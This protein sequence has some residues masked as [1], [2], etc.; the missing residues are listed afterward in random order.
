MSKL[1]KLNYEYYREFS[2]GKSLASGEPI[3]SWDALPQNIR[4]AWDWTAVRLAGYVHGHADGRLAIVLGELAA[5]WEERAAR[6][7]AKGNEQ[8]AMTLLGTSNELRTTLETF[9]AAP[10]MPERLARDQ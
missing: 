10:Q 4:D 8:T 2:A 3:P 9:A 6:A 1:G 5:L 7:D